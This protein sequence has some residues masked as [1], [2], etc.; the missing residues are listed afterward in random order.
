MIR[1]IRRRLIIPQGDTGTVT[2]P[3]LGT[4]ENGDV[5]VLLIT[6]P[7]TREVIFEKKIDAT[8]EL[9]SFS[10]T[11]DETLI[12]EPGKYNWDIKIYYSPVYDEEGKLIGGAEVN[13]YYS[14]FR[15]PVCEI[16]R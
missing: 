8:P 3:T 11:H 2:I 7:L 9:L 4:V 1:L 10:F 16:R 5:A 6:N 15:L 13:S 12:L 14:A